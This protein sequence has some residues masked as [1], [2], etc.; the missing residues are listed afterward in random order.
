VIE[1]EKRTRLF[2]DDCGSSGESDQDEAPEEVSSKQPSCD[3]TVRREDP[4]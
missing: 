3:P 1:E 2:L 4:V